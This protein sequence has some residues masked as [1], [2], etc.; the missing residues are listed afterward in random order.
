MYREFFS[1]DRVPGETATRGG[2]NGRDLGPS[3]AV[4]LCT[5]REYGLQVAG[6]NFGENLVW[7]D[8]LPASV[9]PCQRFGEGLALSRGAA[10]SAF[11]LA[12]VFIT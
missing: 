12:A 11:F 5:Y 2:C 10:S 3:S 4:A 8:M 1:H 9:L 6:E 7:V